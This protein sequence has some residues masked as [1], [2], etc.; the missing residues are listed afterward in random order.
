MRS[1]SKLE[2]EVEHILIETS[3][4]K[5]DIT[6][7]SH[8]TVI[9]GDSA[10]KKSYLYK[11]IKDSKILN[12]VTCL[13]SRN[14]EVLEQINNLDLILPN[15]IGSILFIDEDEI[16]LDNIDEIIKHEIWLVIISRDDIIL[17]CEY[18][19]CYIESSGKNHYLVPYGRS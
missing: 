18:D 2:S 13:S 1:L 19:E 14:V 15:Y 3:R 10:S 7:N 5:F 12:S 17:N 11:L 6:L 9:K 4:V 8:V 16:S